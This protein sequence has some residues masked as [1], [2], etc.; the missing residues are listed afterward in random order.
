[1]SSSPSRRP[2]HLERPLGQTG[3]PIRLDRLA[4]PFGPVPGV[5][6]VLA[7]TLG[8]DPVMCRELD[9]L[10][11]QVASDIARHAGTTPDRVVVANG[12]DELID[13]LLLWRRDRGPFVTFPPTDPAFL[14]RARQHG[15]ETVAWPREPD[16]FGIDLGR[17]PALPPGAT[18]YVMAPNDPTGTG[19]DPTH[20]VRL[21]RA[22]EVVLVD[23]RHAA[24]AG[25]NAAALAS[26]FDNVVILSTLATW[27]GLDVFPLAYAI[28]PARVIAALA[29]FRRP[30]GIALP[31]LAAA[32]ATFTDLDVV[33]GGVRRLRLE[34]ARLWRTLRKS[35]LVSLPHP[36]S[37]NFL[38]VRVERGDAPTVAAALRRSGIAV[39]VPSDPTLSTDHLR[40]TVGPPES[41]AAL[42]VAL[43]EIAATLS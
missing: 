42:G 41:T 30:G 10:L 20:L 11:A 26:E 4:N 35:N 12:M 24:Y 3:A 34:R 36:S 7:A 29:E 28:G 14:T 23:E 21:A 33:L 31:T 32:A 43:T 2:P 15:L 9:L 22:C 40:I 25:R 18:A 1:M 37:A 17:A 27:A 39:H 13:A 8:S 16:R 5:G 6:R 38:L 19:L